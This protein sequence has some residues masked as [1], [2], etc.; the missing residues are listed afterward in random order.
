M[1]T[2][3]QIDASLKWKLEDIYAAEDLWEAD[4]AAAQ[5]CWP[6][7]FGARGQIGKSADALFAALSDESRL[8]LLIERVYAYAHLR[9]DEDNG[10]SNIRA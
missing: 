1:K 5:A 10:T 6:T 8:G 2:R 4:F 9:K 7:P 3:D